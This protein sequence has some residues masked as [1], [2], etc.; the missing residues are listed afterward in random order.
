MKKLFLFFGI[1]VSCTTFSW[2]WNP[3]DYA[4]TNLTDTKQVVLSTIT[5]T[6]ISTGTQAT[7]LCTKGDA[8][9]TVIYFSP[10]IRPIALSTGTVFNNLSTMFEIPPSTTSSSSSSWIQFSPDG[11]NSPWAGSLY[12]IVDGSGTVTAAVFRAK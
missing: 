4:L 2:S 6:A 8:Q 3:P 9:R 5:S 10:S 7:Q 1:V 12:A 11:V